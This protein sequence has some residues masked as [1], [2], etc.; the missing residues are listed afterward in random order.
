MEGILYYS[1]REYGIALPQEAPELWEELKRTRQELL[2]LE[3]ALN[4]GQFTKNPTVND[5]VSSHWRHDGRLYVI[6]VNL[7]ND[8]RNASVALPED[9]TGSPRNFFS[10]RPATLNVSGCQ[11]TGGMSGQEVQVYVLGGQ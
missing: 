1:W 9:F 5:I 6:A 11:L 3:P 8:G 10:G 2:V 4:D 7:S